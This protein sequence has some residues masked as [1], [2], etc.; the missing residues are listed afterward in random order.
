[1]TDPEALARLTLMV[2][3]TSVPTLDNTE[4]ADLLELARRA[5]RYGL[6][7]SDTGWTGTFD[8]NSAAAEGW[9]RK[10]GKVAGAFSFTAD[11]DSY[12]EAQVYAQCLQ[13]AAQYGKRTVAS[14]ST[15]RYLPGEV[16]FVVGNRPELVL[17]PGFAP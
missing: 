1:M 10:A 4:L 3:A 5:D 14:V 17:P 2:S 9:R 6:Y 13:M 8:L 15:G 16:D 12:S 11:G 7:P